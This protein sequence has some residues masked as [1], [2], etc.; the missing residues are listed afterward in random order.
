MRYRKCLLAIWRRHFDALEL[1]GAAV[2]RAFYR[3]VMPGMFRYLVLC[4]HNINLLVLVI[5][6]HIFRATLHAL[7]R[8]FARVIV[9]AFYAAVA[10]GNIAGPGAVGRHCQSCQEECCRC[11]CCKSYLHCFLP[12]ENSVAF[13]DRPSCHPPRPYGITRAD[14]SLPSYAGMRLA[15]VVA[16]NKKGGFSGTLPRPHSRESATVLSREA[17]YCPEPEVLAAVVSGAFGTLR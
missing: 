9:G 4:I 17:F 13:D 11:D 14:G 10:V 6:E 16:R 2:Y 8:A 7:D 5:D 1:K 3:N 15:E 12:Q